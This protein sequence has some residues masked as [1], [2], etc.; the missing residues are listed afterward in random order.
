[1]IHEFLLLMKHELLLC[2]LLFFILILKIADHKKSNDQWILIVSGLL[3]FNFIAGFFWNSGGELFNGM[4]LLNELTIFQKNILNLGILVVSLQAQPYLKTHR[5]VPE[6]YMLLISTLIGMF[7]MI[8]SGNLLLFYIGLEMATI[9]LAAM[10]N[11][12]LKDRNSSEAGMKMILSS[13][14]SSAILLLGISLV[15]GLTGSLSFVEIS[16]H[17]TDTSLLLFA[18]V[19]LFTGFAFKLSAVP[20]HFWTADVYEGSPAVVAAYLSV[21]SKASIAFVFISVLYHVFGSL[22]NIW[23][24]IIFVTAVLTIGIG[25]LF[26]IRQD[27]LKRFLAFSSIA[28]VGFILIGI[29]SGTQNGEA[30]VIYFLL[31]Y[32]FSNL[33]AFGVVTLVSAISEKEKISD[34][35]GFYKTNPVLTWVLTLSLFS[36]AGIPP[37]AGFFGKFFLLMAGAAHG[38]YL[39][40]GF[41][42]INMIISMYYYL[43]IVKAMFMDVNESP[44]ERIKIDLLP[45]ISLLICILGL[46]VTG[47]AGTLYSYIQNLS[48]GI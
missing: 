38:N 12:N 37:T 20:F 3:L 39:L 21:V 4:F 47:F 10:V 25:N 28:Q 42:A 18:F 19:L 8:S 1:M 48:A 22:E 32:L 33:G 7:F 9:P 34:Y 27:N 24:G 13:A 40:V 29:S 14:F 6:F 11:F 44:I 5:H 26:A 23:Y 2:I 36:L 41:A 43:R 16:T 17:L 46:L 15:Y 45:S 30:A 31:I 35:K